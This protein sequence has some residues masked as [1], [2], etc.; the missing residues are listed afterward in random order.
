MSVSYT[1][2]DHNDIYC[3][4][5]QR[6]L[7]GL[8]QGSKDILKMVCKN[9]IKLENDIKPDPVRL[10]AELAYRKRPKS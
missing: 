10:D 3:R 4:D 2:F 5:I 8:E 7:K 9:K 6:D 1:Y